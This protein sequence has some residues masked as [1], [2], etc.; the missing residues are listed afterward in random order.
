MK[1]HEGTLLK[2]I[3]IRHSETASSTLHRVIL[4]LTRWLGTLD[5]SY[6][7]RIVLYVAIWPDQNSHSTAGDLVTIKVKSYGSEFAREISTIGRIGG[8]ANSRDEME[9][10]IAYPG[11]INPSAALDTILTLRSH[12]WSIAETRTY[13]VEVTAYLLDVETTVI[14]LTD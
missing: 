7:N 5:A 4:F 2:R 13:L 11:G 3:L 8:T 1:L 14:S 12:T 6:L 10:N 9:F